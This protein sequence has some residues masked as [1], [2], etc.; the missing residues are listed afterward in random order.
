MNIRLKTKIISN[1]HGTKIVH[2]SD[3]HYGR[4]IK[5]KQLKELLKKLIRL[6][7]IL[8]SLLVI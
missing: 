1:F 3:I 2:L 6:I 5:D 4:T 7:P 8:L